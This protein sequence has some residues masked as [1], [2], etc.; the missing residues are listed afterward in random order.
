MNEGKGWHQKSGGSSRGSSAATPR[1]GVPPGAPR[2][3]C[4]VPGENL[5]H[6]YPLLAAAVMVLNLL[7][8][9]PNHPGW[10]SGK[11]SDFAICFF[12]PVVLVS[13]FEWMGML[14]GKR[15]PAGA[16]AIAVAC[17]VTAAYFSLLQ[18]VRPIADLHV[19]VLGW[20]VSSRRF[21]VTPD[22]TDL[23]ALPFVLLAF[24]WLLRRS[25]EREAR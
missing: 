14:W 4:Y 5:L 11:L 13:L 16:S 3:K 9:K 7:Y 17:G 20:L 15:R 8:L 1:V 24:L 2:R 10:W 19:N 22:P 18:L 6:P 12:L 21:A 25:R 23:V